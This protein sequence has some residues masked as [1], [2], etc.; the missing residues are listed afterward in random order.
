MIETLPIIEAY[1]NYYSGF[2]S[3]L[4]ESIRKFKEDPDVAP[5]TIEH[6]SSIGFDK[7]FLENVLIYPS[8]RPRTDLPF[9]SDKQL[10]VDDNEGYMTIESSDGVIVENIYVGKIRDIQARVLIP[11]IRYQKGMSRGGFYDESDKE[12]CGTFYYYEPSSKYYLVCR[13]VLIAPNKIVAYLHLREQEMG[14]RSDDLRDNILRI[15]HEGL[16]DR[17]RQSNWIDDFSEVK[18]LSPKDLGKSE[19]IL[20]KMMD[21]TYTFLKHH[22]NMYAKEDFL[23]QPLCKLAESLGY[24][25]VLLTTMTG[26]NRIVTEVLDTREREV[27]FGSIVE[28]E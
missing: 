5:S 28:I 25:V 22:E 18:D 16:G 2:L 20:E 7:V 13:R 26:W 6:L 4:Q 12:F 15:I 3:S 8:G 1:K 10:F 17:S 14:P 23:D 24:E 27:S 19:V 21:G 9:V 11:V